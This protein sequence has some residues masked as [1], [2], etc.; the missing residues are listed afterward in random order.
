[1]TDAAAG[2]MSRTSLTIVCCSNPSLAM[3]ADMDEFD[4]ERGIAISDDPAHPPPPPPLADLRAL[5]PLRPRTSSPR[6]PCSD[7][8]YATT[9]SR[10]GLRPNRGLYTADGVVM[11]NLPL[12]SPFLPLPPPLDDDD[13]ECRAV[14][15]RVPAA[16]TTADAPPRVAT[17][18][19]EDD[20]SGAEESHTLNRAEYPSRH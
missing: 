5:P 8:E 15:S 9:L 19:H 6:R 20:T 10:E 18:V 2:Y 1:M 4:V 7:D 11:A 13:E 3:L 16:S 12:P 17:V 14:S